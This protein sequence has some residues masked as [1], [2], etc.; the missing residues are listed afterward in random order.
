MNPVIVGTMII[1]LIV[2]LVFILIIG[3]FF[4]LWIQAKAAKADITMLELVGMW[5]RKV[6]TRIIVQSKIT[7]IQ[8]GLTVRTQD[9]ESHYLS[10]GR[11]PNVVRALIA[12]NRK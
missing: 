7:A 11:V 10:G 6:N 9:L 3:R 1:V 2:L 8:A 5:L 12:A 4:G